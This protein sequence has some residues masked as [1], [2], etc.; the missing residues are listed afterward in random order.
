MKYVYLIALIFVMS[1][2]EV[3]ILI[4]RKSWRKEN[5]R[6]NPYW[7]IPQD[8]WYKN[9]DSYHTSWGIALVLILEMVIHYLP[10]YTFGVQ[11]W[12]MIQAWVVVY[13][14]A[15]SQ[16]RNLFMYAIYKREK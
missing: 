15:I 9:F 4:D 8:K 1:Y 2:R 6:F 7:Y 11:H 5:L 3:Q 12:L 10:M 16:L 14:L 13:W